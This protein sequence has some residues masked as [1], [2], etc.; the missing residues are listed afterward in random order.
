MSTTKERLNRMKKQ[1]QSTL[2]AA[3]RQKKRNQKK[4]DSGCDAA[5]V[6]GMHALHTT[7]SDLSS[8]Q[9]GTDMHSGHHEGMGMS[10]SS[11]YSDSG[12]TSDSSD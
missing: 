3:R 6:L 10:D 8:R 5:F 11:G 2:D 9:S 7:N 1:R 12:S 4:Q